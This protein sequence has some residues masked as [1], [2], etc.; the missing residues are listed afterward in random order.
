MT[1]AEENGLAG[2]I[3][4]RLEQMETVL[5]QRD[6]LAAGRFTIADLLMADVLRVDMT[7][8][9]CPQRSEARELTPPGM[10]H[11]R[12]PGD[13]AKWHTGGSSSAGGLSR[14][15]GIGPATKPSGRARQRTAGRP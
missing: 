2:W 6:W 10:R 15:A 14:S 7:V 5:S 13:D 12:M 11:R 3:Q 9:R 4:S 8:L 1:G